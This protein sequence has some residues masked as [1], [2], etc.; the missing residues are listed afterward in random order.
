M[1]TLWAPRGLSVATAAALAPKFTVCQPKPG[2]Q[3][4]AVWVGL[5]DYI[6]PTTL[7]FCGKVLAT[8]TTG[9]THID[10][11]E[12]ER[13]GIE[14]LSLQGSNLTD[15]WA[16]AEHTLGLILSLMRRIPAACQHV[17]AG[18]W[19]RSKFQGWELR[20][21]RAL[22]IGGGRVGKQ[23]TGFLAGFGCKVVVSNSDADT[24]HA[25]KMLQPNIVTLHENYEP[26]KRGK[27]SHPFFSKFKGAYFINTARGELVDEGALVSAIDAGKVAGCAVDVVADEYKPRR[28]LADMS[29]DNKNIIVTPH[30]AGNTHESV[31]KTEA[32]L[33]RKLLER[34]A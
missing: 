7:S 13:R 33:A 12:C 1:H 10:L 27:Y 6:G 16:T 2:G 32:I 26:S 31:A 5:K 3:V 28:L 14:V 34:F 29:R 15:I 23:V 24:K 30:I 8:P 18:K 9:L 19:D 11:K 4:D 17:H 25:M 22:V 20:G 21:K